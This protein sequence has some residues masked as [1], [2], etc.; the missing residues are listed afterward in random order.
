MPQDRSS[1]KVEDELR[2]AHAA[3][4]RSP[5]SGALDRLVD[6]MAPIV[7]ARVA[8]CLLRQMPAG[9]GRDVRQ[10][11]EDLMQ[12]TFLTLLAK[13]A[14]VLRGWNPDQGLSLKNFVGL[15]AERRTISI[16]RIG[17]RSPW[18]EDPTLTEALDRPSRATGPEEAASSRDLF[19]KVLR[20]LQEELSP[21]GRH[22]FEL[23]FLRELSVADACQTTGMSSDA[24]YAWR[25][26][27]RRLAGKVFEELKSEGSSEK[28][29][30]V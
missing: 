13:D 21:L 20:R 3:W 19:V 16:L 22:L 12:E 2:R 30:Q 4:L 18:K 7:Q 8:R 27:L 25:S 14:K 15:V 28:R 1:S 10:E 29:I 26:R 5:D 6:S 24:I 11:V 9:R 23:L 17:K